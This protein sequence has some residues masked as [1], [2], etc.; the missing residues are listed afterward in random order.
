MLLAD[1]KPM[2][3]LH[4]QPLWHHSVI[5]LEHV[6]HCASMFLRVHSAR[7]CSARCA[8]IAPRRTAEALISSRAV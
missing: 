2:K 3:Y 6:K 7:S 4:A 5:R 8:V 1:N